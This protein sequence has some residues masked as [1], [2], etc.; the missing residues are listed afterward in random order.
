[1]PNYVHLQW[2][3]LHLNIEKR[4][5]DFWKCRKRYENK[6]ILNNGN[7]NQFLRKKERKKNLIE[8]SFLS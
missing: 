2:N 3:N 5:F 4:E 7:G 6:V 8:F 1:M